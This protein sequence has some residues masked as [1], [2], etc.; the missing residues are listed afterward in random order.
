MYVMRNKVLVTFELISR[1][2][3]E[4]NLECLQTKSKENKSGLDKQK[5]NALLGVNDFLGR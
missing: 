4:Q 2:V 3:P 1:N 5:M